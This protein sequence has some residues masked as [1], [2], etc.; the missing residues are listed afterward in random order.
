M[1]G[2]V[3]GKEKIEEEGKLGN[4]EKTLKILFRGVE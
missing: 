2:G 1:G 3:T 4:E